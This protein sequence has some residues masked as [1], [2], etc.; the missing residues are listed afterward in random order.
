MPDRATAHPDLDGA[1]ATLGLARR[2]RQAEHRNVSETHRS[3]TRERL[4]A[5]RIGWRRLR[6]V[7]GT[8]A[9]Q[10]YS[11]NWLVKS[12]QGAKDQ[13]RVAMSAQIVN[14]ARHPAAQAQRMRA[15]SAR[16]TT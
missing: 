6:N 1:G 11:V 13:P 14:F 4:P 10:D 2:T 3:K 12:S 9:S 8:L 16:S 7:S 15:H 5:S